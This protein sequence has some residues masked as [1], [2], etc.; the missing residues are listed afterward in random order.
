MPVPDDA[1]A[2]IAAPESLTTPVGTFD[3]VDGVPTADSLDR[4]YDAAD[5]ITAVQVYLATMP[6]VSLAAMREGVRSVGVTDAQHVGITVPRANSASLYLTANTDTTYAHTFLDLASNG[7]TVIEAPP[8]SLCV[9]DDFWFR[10]I[11]DMG[12]TG[13]DGGAGGKYLFLPPDF[14]GAD[15]PGYH[16]F[17][18]PTYTIWAVFRALDGV[19]GIKRVAVYPLAA[20]DPP[21]TVFIDIADSPHSTVHPNDASFY[22]EIDAIVQEEPIDSLDPERRGLL[23]AI[24]IVKGHPFEPDERMRRILANAAPL[25]AGIARAIAFR[26]RDPEAYYY[27]GSSWKRIFV[28][29]SH[30]FL[31]D[32]ARLLEA[33]TLFHFLATVVTPA[34]TSATPG[35][36]SQYAYTAED[37][38]GAWLDGGRSYRLRLPAGVPATDF[39]SVTVYD[40]QTR[41]F[42]RTDDPYP[43]VSSLSGDV[44]A[45]EDGSI[46]VHF[47][48]T[49]PNAPTTNWI[50]TVPG[51]G[52]FVVLRLYGPLASWFDG[53]WR[54][55]EIEAE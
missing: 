11:T 14:E 13:P 24:G 34:M 32:G 55:G 30:E 18:S 4:L 22:D 12:V 20:E 54:P 35:V 3:F 51:K 19:E 37:G 31:R 8:N 45:N 29:G 52:W 53:A 16:V 40:C 25:A 49:A 42:L 48:P 43:S 9:V 21:E 1:Y 26:P 41:S 10:Y 50:Q 39:W 7:P 44:Q 46:D 27:P 33:R 17:R 2:A 36:G 38:A 5:L 23:A 15:P 6:G 28:G 47:S